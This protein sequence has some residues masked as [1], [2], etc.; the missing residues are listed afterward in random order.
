MS[1]KLSLQ[2]GIRSIFTI[3]QPNCY[4]HFVSISIHAGAQIPR[5]TWLFEETQAKIAQNTVIPLW[6]ACTQ[7]KNRYLQ[8]CNFH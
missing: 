3:P 4:A 5:W 1:M 8:T 2:Q 7:L 6:M